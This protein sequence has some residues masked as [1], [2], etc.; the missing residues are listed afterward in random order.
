MSE[1]R[2]YKQKDYKSYEDGSEASSRGM[3]RPP[4]MPV[5]TDYKETVK[6]DNCGADLSTLFE[7]TIGSRCSKCEAP[8]HTCR[9]CHHFDTSAHWECAQPIKVRV[10]KKSKANECEFFTVRTIS[11]KD[12]GTGPGQDNAPKRTEDHLKALNDLFKK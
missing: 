7:A 3:S 4:R 11:V 5:I 8:M 2:R 6:C 1:D 9:N 12:L 10:F